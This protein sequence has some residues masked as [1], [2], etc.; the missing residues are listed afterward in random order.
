MGEKKRLKNHLIITLFALLF[1]LFTFS[2]TTFAWYVYQTNAHTT[3]VHMAVG[4]GVSLQISDSYDSGFGTTAVLD[5]FNGSLTPVSTDRIQNGFQK[6]VG[7]TEPENQTQIPLANLFG[8]VNH[9]E[10]YRTELYIRSK[11]EKSN[12]YLSNIGF[13]DDSEQYPISTGIRVGFLIHEPGYQKPVV[14]EYIFSI[15]SEHHEGAQYNTWQ[16]QDGYVLDSTKTDG[17]VVEF[18]SLYNEN[19]YCN[20][21]SNNGKVTLKPDSIA[22]LQTMGDGNG[23]YGEPVEVEVFIW[24]EG[25]DQDCTNSITGR[26]L[27][28]VALDF[29]NLVVGSE[30]DG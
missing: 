8:S 23:N 29:A 10:Y 4:T 20:Y 11:G 6:V 24:L 25:C 9:S 15:N 14:A 21:D 13:E 16:G 22:L 27:S 28:N 5:E 7:F 12:V 26:T 3:S 18:K 19:N 2:V 30:V 1:T 17:S